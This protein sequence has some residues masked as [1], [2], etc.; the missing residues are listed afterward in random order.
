METVKPIDIHTANCNAE[1]QITDIKNVEELI[2]E[3]E[4]T[5]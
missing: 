4:G 2:Y 3:F 1:I 5:F